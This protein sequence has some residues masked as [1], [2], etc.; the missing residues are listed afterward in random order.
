MPSTAVMLGVPAKV[1]GCIIFMFKIYFVGTEIIFAT[2]PRS[3]GSIC[4]EV[5]YVAHCV[6]AK[7]IV[8]AGGAQAIAV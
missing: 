5:L 7:M 3:D 8:M 6:G 4:P 1:A 2:P